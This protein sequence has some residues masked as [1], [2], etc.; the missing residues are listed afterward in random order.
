V[1]VTE[2]REAPVAIELH[3]ALLVRLILIPTLLRVRFGHS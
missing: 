3:D 2:V 1:A